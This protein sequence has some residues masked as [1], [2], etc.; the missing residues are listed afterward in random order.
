[1]ATISIPNYNG[2]Y[3][4]P[5]TRQSSEYI[6]LE[7]ISTRSQTFDWNI[8][9][10]IHTHL[11]QVF[12]VEKGEVRFREA[13]Q[14][15]QIIAPCLFF[16][17]PT[18]LHGLTYRPDIEGYI[19]TISA[20]IIDDIFKTAKDIFKTFEKIQV[21]SHFDDQLSFDSILVLIKALEKEIFGEQSER[22]MMLK[23]YL[24]QFFIK[25]HRM[26]KHDGFAKSDSRTLGYFRQFQKIIR[27]SG[28][29]K[30]IAELA[31]ELNITP[32]HLNRVC[33]E[34]SG[35]S[36]LELVHQNLIIEAQKYL[37]HTS[38]SVSEISYLLKFEYPNYFARFFKK[39]IGMTPNGYRQQSGK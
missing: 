16:V 34:V 4:D 11:Y 28:E 27:N 26:A 7:L 2:L 1:M 19:L 31:A 8:Q 32:V 12:I 5:T 29:T 21:L 25:L 10:H 30:S 17:P 39:K 18:Q 35:K 9:P 36:P 24:V 6:F 22:E 3:G 38:Y 33:R 13:T 37:L 20:S 23:T 15:R 14:V